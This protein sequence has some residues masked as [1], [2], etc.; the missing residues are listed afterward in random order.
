MNIQQTRRVQRSEVCQRDVDV[1]NC[2][3]SL[4]EAV[5]HDTQVIVDGMAV[6]SR[7]PVRTAV[8]RCLV[9]SQRIWPDGVTV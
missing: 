5:R 6:E 1:E 3:G 4:M 2:P 8:V 9:G 7:L